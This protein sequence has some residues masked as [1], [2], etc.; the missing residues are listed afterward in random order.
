MRSRTAT[1]AVVAVAQFLIAL[2]YSITQVALPRIAAE[3]RLDGTSTPWVISAYAVMFAGLLV[4]GGR[5]TD[6]LGAR[7][8][9]ALSV[10]AFGAASAAGAA[11]GDPATLLVARGGQG[12]GAALL[13]PAVLALIG[14]SFPAG[15]P[16]ARALAVWGSVGA[17]GLAAGSLLGGVL[18]EISWR[19]TFLVNVPVPVPLAI[20][21]LTRIPAA[22]GL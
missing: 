5:L 9:F 6:R 14:T 17:S 3:L 12:V 19:L 4:A 11:A 21:A 2:D 15:A 8:V 16:R 20:I 18:T 10:L 13:Q 1:L 22:P 7:R